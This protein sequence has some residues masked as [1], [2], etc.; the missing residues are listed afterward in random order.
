MAPG[1]EHSSK[2]GGDA[3]RPYTPVSPTEM[4]GKF[5]LL[6]KVYQEWGDPQHAHSYKP[7]G[8]VS[9]FINGLALGET[10]QFKHIEKNIKI[11]YPFTGVNTITM[12]AVGAGWW[13]ELCVRLGMYM[14]VV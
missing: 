10:V 9:N 5:Q 4:K 11:Q 14:C 6:V 12:L 3:I 8:A 7:A 13:R 1:Q 2:G